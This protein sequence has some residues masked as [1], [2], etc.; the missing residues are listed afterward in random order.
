MNIYL[1][2][3]IG[4]LIGVQGNEIPIFRYNYFRVQW[5]QVYCSI[6]HFGYRCIFCSK[7]GSR[8]TQ[9][10]WT[11]ILVQILP[12]K[13]VKM[14]YILALGNFLKYNRTQKIYSRASIGVED[15]IIWGQRI[16]FKSRI[17]KLLFRYTAVVLRF[18][19]SL[20]LRSSSLFTSSGSTCFL[21]SLVDSTHQS[22]LPVAC[23]SVLLSCLRV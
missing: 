3:T 1:V 7:Y 20:R 9:D 6:R 4:I 8:C 22:R 13:S 2:V 15:I 23:T 21:C 17:R 5:K 14:Y 19:D 16:G 12:R 11:E 18:S 10:F